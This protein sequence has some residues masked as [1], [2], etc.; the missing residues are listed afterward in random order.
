MAEQSFSASPTRRCISGLSRPRIDARLLLGVAVLVLA[1]A[2]AAPVHASGGCLD[3]RAEL[4]WVGSLELDGRL[5]DVVQQDDTAYLTYAR[6]QQGF[7]C[8]LDLALPAEPRL[9]NCVETA[10]LPWDLDH[11]GDLAIVS[12]VE[13]GA[14]VFDVSDPRHPRRVS[15]LSPRHPP[16]G[17]WLVNLLDGLGCYVTQNPV[18]V[19]IFEPDSGQSI[20]KVSTPDN[21]PTGV[22]SIG[23]LIL[24]SSFSSGWPVGVSTF[25]IVDT[26][27]PEQP[28]IAFEAY[29]DSWGVGVAVVGNQLVTQSDEGLRLIDLADPT[30][31][32]ARGPFPVGATG[33][34]AV[35]GTRLHVV[36]QSGKLV[37][38]D[39][40]GDEPVAAGSIPLRVFSLPSMFPSTPIIAKGNYVYVGRDDGIDAYDVAEP[41]ALLPVTA[42]QVLSVVVADVAV[43]DGIACAVGGAYGGQLTVLDV[44][45]PGT[46]SIV[47]EMVGRAP[48]DDVEVSNGLAFISGHSEDGVLMLD[49][50]NPQNPTHVAR[51]SIPAGTRA[52]A[53][54]GSHV[55]VAHTLGL[56]VGEP[57]RRHPRG[58]VQTPG[59]ALDVAVDG[60]W[61]YVA[62]T[63]AGLVV[64]DVQDPDRPV[65]KG[66]MQTPKRMFSV[67]IE[68]GFAFVGALRR[69]YV[70]DLAEPDAPVIV[71]DVAASDARSIVTDGEFA[72]VGRE[73]F[74][75]SI[76]SQPRLVG[77]VDA[78]PVFC[79]SGDHFYG[80][81]ALLLHRSELALL[82]KQCPRAD[83]VEEPALE[84]SLADSSP[85]RL[86]LG[87]PRPNPFQPALL[88][89]TI[90]VALAE[91]A[92]AAVAIYDVAGRRIRQLS[93]DRR[94]AGQHF[95]FWDGRDQRGRRVGAGV[96]FVRLEVGDSSVRRSVTLLN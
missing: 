92:R 29:A 3:Y 76:P 91:P 25:R 88:S 43:A 65:I 50:S 54:A 20:G 60:H 6:D 36:D 22:H 7:L 42:R 31:P 27:N 12:F 62:D 71:A 68:G 57:L 74:D 21:D 19:H 70:A 94:A 11:R 9:V 16:S 73:V 83:P 80:R 64:V 82:P 56:I 1:L 35:A 45:E 77:L 81:S 24:V 28:T 67:E 87:Y 41:R 40:G 89:T 32:V 55:Y 38:V 96:Y 79:A 93:S 13:G 37:S 48:W 72:Y 5:A 30:Q 84:P 34:A 85:P 51:M 61:A 52:L 8:V 49:I 39:M 75:I 69:M 10:G 44:T 46:P 15:L 95:L 2:A 18:E 58:Q 86:R 59:T 47:A 26:T 33:A 66:D 63:S 17:S 53:V 78:D 14:E 23:H 4:A 90:E